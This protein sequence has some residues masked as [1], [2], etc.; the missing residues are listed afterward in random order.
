MFGF[1]RPHLP[2]GFHDHL[3]AAYKNNYS[4]LVQD[5]V[6]RAF[7]RLSDLTRDQILNEA[8]ESYAIAL[9]LMLIYADAFRKDVPEPLPAALQGDAR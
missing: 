2:R 3:R 5:S 4:P 9:M 1:L 6:D 8:L 7:Q